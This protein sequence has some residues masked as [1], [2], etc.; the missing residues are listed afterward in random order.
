MEVILL[1]FFIYLLIT[2]GATVLRVTGY[3][4]S[5]NPRFA[6][7]AGG[8]SLIASLV[9]YIFKGYVPIEITLFGVTGFLIYV[10]YLLLIEN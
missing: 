4:I 7:K 2:T 6:L 10:L 1:I 3:V 8:S 9:G 5:N